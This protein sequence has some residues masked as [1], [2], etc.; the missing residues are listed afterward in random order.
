MKMINVQIREDNIDSHDE[1][2]KY[3]GHERRDE[4]RQKEYNGHGGLRRG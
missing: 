4:S 2:A 3:C 1:L